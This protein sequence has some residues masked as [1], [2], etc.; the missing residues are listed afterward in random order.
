MIALFFLVPP[1]IERDGAPIEMDTRKATALLAYLSVTKEKH[2]RDS[3][4]NLLWPEYDD[5][6]ARAALRRTLSTLRKGLGPDLL[7]TDRTDVTLNQNVDVQIDVDQFHQLHAKCG[8]HA[9]GE[10]ETERRNGE[11]GSP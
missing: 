7:D 2:S 6:R 9:H 10:R 3:L 4:L 1:R 8:T 5:T 11:G